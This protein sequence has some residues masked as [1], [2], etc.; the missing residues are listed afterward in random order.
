MVSANVCTVR[1]VC[2][3]VRVCDVSPS[4]STE[5]ALKL[6]GVLRSVTAVSVYAHPSII[7]ASGW[8]RIPAARADHVGSD[9]SKG[10]PLVIAALVQI[11][12]PPIARPT[13]VS[14]LD[15]FSYAGPRTDTTL[16][17]L[18]LLAL[19]HLT[20]GIQHLEEQLS[21]ILRSRARAPLDAARRR[22]VYAAGATHARVGGGS[23]LYLLPPDLAQVIVKLIEA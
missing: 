8:L 5:D 17:D 21:P 23:T 15:C 16:T 18:S 4:G 10:L 22:L 14:G 3:A 13:S 9:A 6:G 1:A 12:E 20:I 19:L 2:D 7:H 11:A